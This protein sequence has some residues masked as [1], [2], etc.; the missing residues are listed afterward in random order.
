MAA[1]VCLPK[2]WVEGCRHCHR[3]KYGGPQDDGRFGF[4]CQLHQRSSLPK[5]SIILRSSASASAV[6]RAKYNA[7]SFLD[8]VPNLREARVNNAVGFLRRCVSVFMN[9]V[10]SYIILGAQFGKSAGGQALSKL[11]FRRSNPADATRSTAIRTGA[12]RTTPKAPPP[13]G[14]TCGIANHQSTRAHLSERLNH[15]R[16]GQM[17]ESPPADRLANCLNRVISFQPS[18][19]QADGLTNEVD[20]HFAGQK[21]YRV[22]DLARGVW[23]RPSGAR[24]PDFPDNNTSRRALS[25]HY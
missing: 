14:M 3:R 20:G 21:R 22:A 18:A 24:H 6:L 2:L 19:N 5:R 25:C 17:D 8:G 23:P 1:F 7:R 13:R 10:S 4:G 15:H 9:V 12:I 16:I 11:A